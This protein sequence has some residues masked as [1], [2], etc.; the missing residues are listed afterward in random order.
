MNRLFDLTSPGFTGRE[1]RLLA[2]GVR[3][4]MF[5]GQGQRVREMRAPRM[6]KDD[7]RFLSM[8]TPSPFLRAQAGA[9][10]QGRRR[11]PERAVFR[12]LP[13]QHHPPRR[14]PDEHRQ[15]HYKDGILAVTLQKPKSKAQTNRSSGV[16]T[17]NTPAAG[18][19][20]LPASGK[21]HKTR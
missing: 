11:L 7:M 21:P 5:S 12:P 4:W 6:K 15:A 8:T 3:P 20:C 14:C 10:G 9:R 18:D 13:P 2:Y 17:I 16:L 1:D 19:K